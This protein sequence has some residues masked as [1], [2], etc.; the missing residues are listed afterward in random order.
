M[1]ILMPPPYKNDTSLKGYWKFDETS[2]TL[3]D[4]SGNGNTGT[5]YG[6]PMYGIQGIFGTSIYLNGTD[7][8]VS[9]NAVNPGNIISVA[10]WVYYISGEST[11]IS[12]NPGG[13]MF[14]ISGTSFVNWVDTDSI[15][16]IINIGDVY[17]KWIH[18]AWTTNLTTGTTDLYKNGTFFASNTSNMLSPSTHNW[19]AIGRYA[20]GNRY[21]K[22]YIDDLRW[23]AR[24]LT[25]SEIYVQYMAGRRR[26]Q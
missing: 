2:G 23:Y 3:A 9:F 21:Y 14:N 17:N 4:S 16:G 15:P 6:S 26:T 18:L 22:G 13:S 20:G 24:A 5:V 11:I 19:V 7:S 10:V 25:A 12:Q 1:G 8:Y